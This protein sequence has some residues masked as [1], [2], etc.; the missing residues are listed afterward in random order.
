MAFCSD[1]ITPIKTFLSHVTQGIATAMDKALAFTGAVRA[2]EQ[3]ATVQVLE[4][5]VGDAVHVDIKS[6]V[7]KAFTLITGVETTVDNLATNLSN[8][9]Q[10]ETSLQ[11]NAS[12]IKLASVTTSINSQANGEEAKPESFYDTAVQVHALT[13]PVVIGTK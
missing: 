1:G 2:V 10:G 13:N 12:L 7:A 4:E 3:S 8:S 11:N 6:D 9:L 5:I